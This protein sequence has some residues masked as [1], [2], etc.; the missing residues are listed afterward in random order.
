METT[1]DYTA[2]IKWPFVVVFN[3]ND[4]PEEVSSVIIK[5]KIP[6]AGYKEFHLYARDLID[7]ARLH[8]SGSI[9]D[10]DFVD[11]ISGYF[12][13]SATAKSADRKT[14]VEACRS[15]LEGNVF[16]RKIFVPF[17]GLRPREE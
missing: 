7:R 11:D 1:R 8:I 6:S 10:K 14:L 5:T 17:Y 13:L 12:C 2:K 4:G 9:S 16:N 15:V 3:L